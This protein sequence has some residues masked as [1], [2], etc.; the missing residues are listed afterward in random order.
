M[1]QFIPPLTLGGSGIVYS[2][3]GSGARDMLAGGHRT[4]FM[5]AINEVLTLANSALNSANSAIGSANATGT[6]VTSIASATV[7]SDITIAT[8]SGK[9]WVPGMSLIVAATADPYNKWITGLVKTY[10]S[11]TLV[12]TVT[13]FNGAISGTTWTISAG[14]LP[15]PVTLIRTAV[16]AAVLAVTVGD[17]G[18]FLDFTGGTSLTLN[19]PAAATAGAGWYCYVANSTASNAALTATIDP[20]S[21]ELIDA[22]A[23]C[24]MYAGEVRLLMCTGTEWRSTVI[25]PYAIV[26]TTSITWT[27][28]SGYSAHR[29]QLRGA[30]GGGGGGGGSGTESGAGGGGGGG[31]ALEA[32]FLSLDLSATESVVVGVGGTAG[33][34]GNGFYGGIGGVGGSSS[35]RSL[36]ANGGSGGGRGFAFGVAEPTNPDGGAGALLLTGLDATGSSALTGA[37]VAASGVAIAGKPGLY[38]G[39]GASAAM[40]GVTRTGA[41]GGNS[42]YGGAGGGS[43]G[44]VS[45]GV[46]SSGA[47]GGVSLRT[48]ASFS[49]A[50]GAGGAGNG[51]GVGAAGIAGAAAGGGGGGGGAGSTI[52]GVGGAGGAGLAVIYGLA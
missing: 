23:T 14:A 32:D 1:T 45:A 21:A 47:A 44:G 5:L 13:D 46:G 3:D 49:G 4:N 9:V 6:S 25:R 43:G 2:D 10:S 33:T 27:K 12:I 7:G 26:S 36:V 24:V 42:V 37:A 22:S 18:R 50:G 17:R 19:L 15:R 28:P 48:T 8:Q 16:T 52:G 38:S 34:G 11:T 31:A 40:P 35:F 51:A 20:S 29:V 39:G 41:I 30:G